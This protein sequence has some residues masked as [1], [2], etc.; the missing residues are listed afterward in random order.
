MA[1]GSLDGSILICARHRSR[2]IT[3]WDMQ[4]GGL[5]HTFTMKFEINDIAVSSTG[6][7]LASCS[8]DGTFRFWEVETGSGGSRF[9][10][11]PIVDICWLEPEDQAA[12]AF[13]GSVVVLE[14]TTERT[15]HTFPVG[16]SVRGIAFSPRQRRLAVWLTSG[17]ES[18]IKVISIQTG[19]VLVSSPPLLHV[20][21]FTFSGD[22]DR[23]V[24]A[25]KAGNLL[26]LPV[27][28][29]LTSWRD[30]PHQPGTIHSICHLRSGHLVV[31]V[32]DCIQLLAMEYV[33][34]SRI[35]LDP[36]VSISHVYPLDN[37]KAVC[38]SSRD[39]GDVSLLDVETM[40][41]LASYG[42]TPRDID[43][44]LV[45]RILCASINR[46]TTIL[47][48]P[49]H[50]DGEFHLIRSVFPG[51]RISLP[52]PVTL[53]ALSPGG[54]GIVVVEE[55]ASGG[56]QF[57]V[58]KTL[59]GKTLFSA[60]QA[61][62]PPK[63]IVFTSGTEFYTE[64]EDEDRR[65]TRCVRS[66]FVLNPRLPTDMIRKL[67]EESVLSTHPYELDENLEW[68][69]DAKSRRVCWL[70]PGYVSGTENGHCFA[71]SSIVMAGEDGIVRRLTF[72]EPRSDS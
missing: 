69:I 50:H 16:E 6:R 62:R 72:T 8:P 11:E 49:K 29:T 25:T 40:K 44:S 27:T 57:R 7:Y 23:I 56:W 42:L 48:F 12:L 66:T 55:S 43:P 26:F 46:R 47:N 28:I 19:L 61:G 9:L 41:T 22:G 21:R 39:R 64:Y 24:C 2:E 37:G 20:S 5:I 51:W 38:T 65:V 14:V 59:D 4:T 52:Q 45:P 70:P 67:S 17:I 10:G 3:L 54:G 32:G 63:T 36:E 34:P 58:V 31:G 33:Q 18:T 30:C 35:G 71:G 1:E 15:L 13:K 68:V 53:V 60:I